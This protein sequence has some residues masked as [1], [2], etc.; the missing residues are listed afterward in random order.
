MGWFL[1]FGGQ[2]LFADMTSDDRFAVTSS[3]D[4]LVLQQTPAERIFAI[5]SGS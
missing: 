2:S 3:E 5:E 1:A 4:P